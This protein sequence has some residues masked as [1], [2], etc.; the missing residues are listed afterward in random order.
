M[1][2]LHPIPFGPFSKIYLVFLDSVFVD[3]VLINQKRIGEAPSDFAG[4]SANGIH[5]NTVSDTFITKYADVACDL[6]FCP[7]EIRLFQCPLH[8]KLEFRLQK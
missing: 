5:Y 3:L 8:I 2:I 7:Y 4:I 6:R 1:S